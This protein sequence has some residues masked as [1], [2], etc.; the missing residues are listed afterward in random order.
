MSSSST[1]KKHGLGRGP[2]QIPKAPI[3]LDE[4]ILIQMRPHP[5]STDFA[6]S[7]I[8]KCISQ[9][10]LQNWP[11]PVITWAST[12]LAHKDA[13]WA[14]FQN[15]QIDHPGQAE[16]YMHEYSPWWCAPTIWAGMCEQWKAESWV[17]RRRTAAV[18]RASGAPEGNK[19]PGTY[20][21]GSISQLQ[22]VAARGASSQGQ[23]IHWLD[24]Y[25]ETRDGLP[26]AVQIVETYNTLLD[27]RYPE[28]TSRP[29]IDQELWERV[30]VVKKN[31]VKG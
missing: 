25:V 14:E 7:K 8:V 21:G 2:N 18:N 17:K 5:D 10:C 24:V 19:A 9:L 28:G 20:K 29:P 11:T 23:P 4:R 12:P 1:P 3:N 15:A 30:S 13:V 6:D 26:E 31:Y 16:E 22:H 27:K